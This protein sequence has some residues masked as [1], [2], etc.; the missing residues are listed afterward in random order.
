MR[1]TSSISEQVLTQG[2]TSKGRCTLPQDCASHLFQT[3]Y[4]STTGVA[5]FD[6]KLKYTAINP[7]LAEMN[8]ISVEAHAGKVVRDVLG[9]AAETVERHFLEVLESGWP[10]VGVQTLPP[11]LEHKGEAYRTLDIVPIEG[12]KREIVG[13]LVL[14][15]QILKTQRLKKELS[16]LLQQLQKWDA[17]YAESADQLDD[18]VPVGS[19]VEI[20]QSLVKVRV[21]G[22]TPQETEVLRCLVEGKSTRQIAVEFNRSTKVVEKQRATIKTKLGVNSLS[23]LVLY[24]VKQ[25]ILKV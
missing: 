24:A 23:E 6:R 2:P 1:Q 14:V 5:I 18:W 15:V 22:L 11:N 20:G 19:S 21:A 4:F 10:A 9:G 13:I 7:A 16:L 3:L 8:G 25:G 17:A 12:P